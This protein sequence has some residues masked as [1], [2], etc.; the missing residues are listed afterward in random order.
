VLRDDYL[1]AHHPVVECLGVKVDKPSIHY[2]TFGSFYNLIVVAK[3]LLKSEKTERIRNPRSGGLLTPRSRR[4]HLF[5]IGNVFKLMDKF[6]RAYLSISSVG[7]K[8]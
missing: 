3:S 8:S 4:R 7:L 1:E 5:V 6:L 2:G